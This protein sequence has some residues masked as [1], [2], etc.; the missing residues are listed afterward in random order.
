MLVTLNFESEVHLKGTMVAVAERARWNSKCG[1]SI[2]A[3]RLYETA[4]SLAWALGDAR[5]A[6]VY[7]TLQRR[8]AAML[9]EGLPA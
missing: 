2:A 4:A 5:M 1:C 3:A 8:H 7:E 6:V 9:G